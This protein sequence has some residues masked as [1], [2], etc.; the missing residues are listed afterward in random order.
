MQ[1]QI[2]IKIEFIDIESESLFLFIEMAHKFNHFIDL[3][4][5]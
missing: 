4:R 2:C 3:L 5:L 1:R